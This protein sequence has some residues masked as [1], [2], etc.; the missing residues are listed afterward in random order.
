MLEA[1]GRADEAGRA[2]DEAVRVERP[3]RDALLGAARFRARRGEAEAALLIYER[4]RTRAPDDA[5]V[6][7]E[8][9]ELLE[10]AGR[11]KEALDVVRGPAEGA[12][13]RLAAAEASPAEQGN[14][15]AARR[16][17]HELGSVAARLARRAGEEE[18]ARAWEAAAALSQSH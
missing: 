3:E 18:R 8:S 5:V 6:V 14:G 7:K 1:A 15:V 4:A 9:A 10:S 12:A 13:E 2:W 17:D 11:A 16:A